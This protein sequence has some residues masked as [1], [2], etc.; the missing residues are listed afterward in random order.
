M[1]VLVD[2]HTLVWA[3]TAPE[4]LSPKAKMALAE[5]EVLVSVASLWELILK[6]G[7]KHA[8]VGQ[9]VRWWQKNVTGNGLRVLSIRVQNV[10]LL[11]DLPAVH[12]D[13]F[14]RILVAQSISEIAPIV[15][16]DSK[17]EAYGIQ[18]IW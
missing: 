2:T 12:R 8:L 1:T 15:S 10:S 14:D 3:L 18:V 7:R 13:P 11:E 4:Q 17:L 6:S 9:P 16:K 5:S